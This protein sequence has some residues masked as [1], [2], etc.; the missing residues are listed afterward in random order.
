MRV[1][2]KYEEHRAV[3]LRAYYSWDY[4]LRASKITTVIAPVAVGRPSEGEVPLIVHEFKPYSEVISSLMPVRVI[5]IVDALPE[6]VSIGSPLTTLRHI[7]CL[8][9]EARQLITGRHKDGDVVAVF[10]A[11]K[12]LFPFTIEQPDYLELVLDCAHHVA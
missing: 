9:R 2:R 11:K 10:Q 7:E 1:I 8:E 4:R 6:C 12:R 5:V 3:E